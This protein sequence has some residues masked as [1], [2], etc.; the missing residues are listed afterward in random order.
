MPPAFILVSE[1]KAGNT[2]GKEDGMR[3]WELRAPPAARRH[4]SAGGQGIQGSRAPATGKRMQVGSTSK[5]LTRGCACL[6]SWDGQEMSAVGHLAE[7][8]TLRV[9]LVPPS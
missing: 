4:S 9:S 6:G 1:E 5:P 8:V 2:D 3:Q 7:A